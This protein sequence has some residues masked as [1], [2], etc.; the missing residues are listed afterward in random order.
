MNQNNK[1][2][3][4][5]IIFLLVVFIFVIGGILFYVFDKLSLQMAIDYN[6]K[7]VGKGFEQ[8]IVEQLDDHDTVKNINQVYLALLDVVEKEDYEIIS[9]SEHV[10]KL[11]DFDD[12]YANLDLYLKKDMIEYSIHINY[13]DGKLDGMY[14][15]TIIERNDLTKLFIR[16]DEIKPLLDVLGFDNG[17]YL[18]SEG[19]NSTQLNYMEGSSKVYED[20]YEIFIYE[21]KDN[22]QL[23]YHFNCTFMTLDY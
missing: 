6:K 1:L 2:T 5:D 11:G 12:M 21:Y 14:F 19:Y 20:Q 23:K 17:Y 22:D 16:E 8:I 4:K 18:L 3:N 13:L 15:D 7:Y 10:S 9:S